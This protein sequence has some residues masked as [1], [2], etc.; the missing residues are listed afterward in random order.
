MKYLLLVFFTS[1]C[2]LG[3]AQNTSVPFL[4]KNR[5]EG[6]SMY[7]IPAGI[8][9][10]SG[11]LLA[12]CE[13]RNSLMDHGDIDLVMK[14][15]ADSGR[16]WSALQ[17]IWNDDKNTCGNPTPVVDAVTGDV[18]VIATL[19]NDKV[20]VLRSKNEGQSWEQPVDIT[21]NVKPG[22]WKWYATGPVHA[23]QMQAA[24]YRNRMVVPCNHT[25]TTNN[26]HVSHIIYSDDHG[27]TWQLGGSVSAEKTD[28][29]TVAELNN[30]ELI[31]NMRNNDRALP[32]RKISLSNDGGITW[33]APVFDTTLIEPV[34]QGA[35]LRYSFAPDILLFTNPAHIKKRKNL[36]L[37]VSYNG[38][39]TWDKQLVINKKPAAYSDMVVLPDGGVLCVF[40]T[41]K[42]FPYGG[43]AMRSIVIK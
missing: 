25:S 10:N 33:S 14:S 43:V 23:I 2:L 30:G 40:E 37:R 24:R 17:V 1:Y 15:S 32:D 9:T 22:G 41:G 38:G 29:C 16:T 42:F 35:L 34:C 36:V 4:F 20:F 7:R 18:L 6:Y 19:N 26:N 3:I 13:G 27:Y 39:R 21:A 11:K 5:K 28:E 12:F 31:L 8:K